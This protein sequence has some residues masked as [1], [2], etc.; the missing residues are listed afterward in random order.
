[1]GG[2]STSVYYCVTSIEAHSLVKLLNC[3]K[4][5][6]STQHAANSDWFQILRSYTL[7]MWLPVLMLLNY[8]MYR[9]FQVGCM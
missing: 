8:Y 6:M 2:L 7:I 4:C 9:G 3:A 1:M 5:L